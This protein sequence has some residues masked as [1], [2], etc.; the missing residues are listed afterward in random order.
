[1]TTTNTFSVATTWKV[2]GGLVLLLLGTSAVWYYTLSLDRQS[3]EKCDSLYSR[4]DRLSGVVDTPRLSAQHKELFDDVMVR[5]RG[6]GM[7]EAEMREATVDLIWGII[8]LFETSSRAFDENRD[9]IGTTDTDV[10]AEIAEFRKLM[11]DLSNSETPASTTV[12]LSLYTGAESLVA[13]IEE[14]T[15]VALLDTDAE[16][17]EEACE[18]R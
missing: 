14:L 4:R 18:A 10:D 7:T 6:G 12:L 11:S 8:Q 15:L 3:K 17:R 16:L 2:A 13:E 1:M 9:I 5:Y